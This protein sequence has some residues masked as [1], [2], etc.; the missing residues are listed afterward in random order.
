MTV[1]INGTTGITS[2]GGYVGDGISFADGTPSNTLVTTTGG[3]VGVGISTPLHE[4]HTQKDQ[5]AF[6]TIAVGNGGTA[7]SGTGSQFALIDGS[8][9]VG[10]FRRYRDGTGD[11]E[12]ANK[13]GA[14]KLSTGTTPTERMRIDTS[15]N[16]GIGTNSPATLLDMS[17]SSAG[18]YIG[19]TV[20]NTSSTGYTT[21]QYLIGAS[22]A[23]GT[24]SINYAPGVFFALGPVA[25]DT[26]TPIVFRNN[27][28][29]E[30]MR[31]DS[32]GRTTTP[33]QP[34]FFA[35]SDTGNVTLTNGMTL[36]WNQSGSNNNVGSSYNTTTGLFT[37]PIAGRYF[38]SFQ[39][40]VNSALG[41]ISFKLNGSSMN[42]SQMELRGGGAG[43]GFVTSSVVIY[44]AA[45]DTMGVGD[46]QGISGG[47]FYMGHSFFSGYMVG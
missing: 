3:L 20:R 16:V 42:N 44:L 33:Y 29:T 26:T 35:W 40:F 30:R 24:A 46:W 13:D 21:T 34:M 8:N 12:L 15:G 9:T 37:A 31:I 10:W 14:L 17:A 7:T 32:S 23:N 19:Q 25:N 28:A 45:G 1:I 41:R 2:D 39:L 18:A 38:F 47:I 43:A 5:A 4:L 11:V 22:G 27:N 36:V 6:T